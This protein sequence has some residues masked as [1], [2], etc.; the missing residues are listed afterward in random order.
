MEAAAADAGGFLQGGESRDGVV[1]PGGAALLAG[2][3]PQDGATIL[4]GDDS[5]SGPYPSER[6]VASAC[7]S[8]AWIAS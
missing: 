1:E 6:N 3:E 4:D 8:N 2:A 7:A 5:L